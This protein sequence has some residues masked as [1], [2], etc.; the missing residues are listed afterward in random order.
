MLLTRLLQDHYG[1]TNNHTIGYK[2][3]KPLNNSWMTTVGCESQ[4][5]GDVVLVV[6]KYSHHNYYYC[7]DCNMCAQ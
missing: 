4:R 7:N 5:K 3:E 6:H 2:V 1:T